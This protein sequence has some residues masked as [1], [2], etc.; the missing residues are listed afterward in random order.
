[1]KRPHTILILAMTAD[2]KIADRSRSAA[3]FGSA[4]DKIHLEKQISLVDG[5]LF[6]AGTLR[7]YQTSLLI[8]NPDFLQWR[9]QQNK[10]PQP[11]HLVCSASGNLDPN[12]RFFEQSFPRWLVT[13]ST[14]AKV[15]QSK[16]FQGFDR[17]LRGDEEDNSINWCT[18]FEQLI[19]LNIQTLAILGGGELV[20]SLL[21]DQLIDEFYLTLCP[22][23]LGGKDAPTPVEGLGF[24]SQQAQELELLSFH[25]VEGE[26]FLHYRLHR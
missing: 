5:V 7:A 12:W 17:I 10:P 24:L 8:C 13:T 3:R 1:M 21:E 2:G 14:G 4:A 15:W 19:S 20:A 16:N 25:Q 11:V 22:L 9:H 6:G 26:F 23:I 18:V